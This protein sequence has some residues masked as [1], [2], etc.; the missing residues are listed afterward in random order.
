[1]LLILIL[2]LSR[3]LMPLLGVCYGAQLLVHK[4]GGEVCLPTPGNT[5]GQ[6][7]VFIDSNDP[8]FRNISPGTQVWMSHADTITAF[9]NLS[10]TGS[11]SDV[12]AGAFYIKGEQTWG[13]Q[14]HPEVYHTSEG[15]KCSGTLLLIYA[16]VTGL[17][18]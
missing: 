13:I 10:I 3:A 8:L 15:T 5:A 14:F 12:K 11:T 9:L 2:K 4:S 17:D 6:R 16:G 18:P 1:M 7:L